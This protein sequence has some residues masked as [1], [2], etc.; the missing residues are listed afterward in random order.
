MIFFVLNAS[1][2]AEHDGRQVA[3]GSRAVDRA[4]KTLADKI[5][6]VAAVID[7]GMAEDNGIERRRLKGE[8]NFGA[9]TPFAET[10]GAAIQKDAFAA[11]LD[12]VHRTGNGLSGTE[13][14]Y[15]RGAVG[16]V[17]DHTS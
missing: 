7:V 15:Q 6:Q 12:K 11:G 2:V 14:G 17:H 3:R 4:V 8:V 10:S 5:G 9:R 16:G 13:E 1:G